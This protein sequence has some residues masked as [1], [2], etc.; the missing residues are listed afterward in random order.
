M[1]RK[2]IALFVFVASSLILFVGVPSEGA[3]ASPPETAKGVHATSGNGITGTNVY[4]PEGYTGAGYR[5]WIALNNVH[6]TLP[7]T[8]SV[9]FY[10]ESTDGGHVK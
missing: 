5:N 9:H 1:G 4:L 3:H 2:G 6:D 10:G 7:N 8:V